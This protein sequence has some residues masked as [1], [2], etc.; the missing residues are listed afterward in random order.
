MGE[1]PQ[2]NILGDENKLKYLEIGVGMSPRRRIEI[3]EPKR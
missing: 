3:I 1:V 2:N